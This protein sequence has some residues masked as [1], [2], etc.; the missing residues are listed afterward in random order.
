ML[1]VTAGQT[2]PIDLVL[3]YRNR[4]GVWV[5]PNLTGA[6]PRLTIEDADGHVLFAKDGAPVAPEATSALARF[7]PS[8]GDIA[9]PAREQS[10]IGAFY[11]VR[12]TYADGTEGY[13]PRSGEKAPCLVHRPLGAA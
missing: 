13:F 12:V 6:T 3:E 7:L 9:T 1:E 5:A 2:D 8:P 11:Q 4:A 10:P